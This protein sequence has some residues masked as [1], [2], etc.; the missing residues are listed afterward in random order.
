MAARTGLPVIHLDEHY[1][2][3]DWHEPSTSTW[4]SRV[5]K[6]AAREEWIMD[7]N[8]SGTFDLRMPR[9]DT[10]IFLDRPTWLCLWRVIK[11][12]LRYYGQV[13][14]GSAAGCTERFDGQFLHYVLMYNTTRRAKILRTLGEQKNAGKQ[15]FILQSAADLRKLVAS[16]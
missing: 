14:P 4:R 1:F 16:R 7:G 5:A 12:T 10:I 3:P 8:F 6:L 2:G 15:V 13:R 9:A 11:R